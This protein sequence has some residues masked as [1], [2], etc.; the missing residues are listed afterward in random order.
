[1]TEPQETPSGP[2]NQMDVQ[3]A[4]SWMS[5]QGANF[6]I[7]FQ[8]GEGVSIS[9]FLEHLFRAKELNVRKEMQ[10]EIESSLGKQ[11]SAEF[12]V[13]EM[14]LEVNRVKGLVGQKD[15][16]LIRLQGKLS[17][18]AAML[19]V[20]RQEVQSTR[21][22]LTAVQSREETKQLFGTITDLLRGR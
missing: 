13:T 4:L 16:E 3:E 1:M 11:R 18:A 12:R 21:S 14:E 15:S 5:A 19:E 6:K 8:P 10:L 17:E 7:P 9:V 20:L 22:R 2:E